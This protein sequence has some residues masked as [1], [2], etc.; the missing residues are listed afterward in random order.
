MTP[1]EDIP[2]RA[3]HSKRDLIAGCKSGQMVVEPV[4]IE[5]TRKGANPL[6]VTLSWPLLAMKRDRNLTPF[7]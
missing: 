1:T 2:V 6:R 5:P 7:R 4:G 3:S